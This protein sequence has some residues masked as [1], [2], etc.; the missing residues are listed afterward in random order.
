VA[1]GGEASR[2]TVTNDKRVHNV[3]EKGG[4]EIRVLGD[5]GNAIGRVDAAGHLVQGVESVAVSIGWLPVVDA[6]DVGCR[7][8]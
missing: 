1:R 6:L 8:S 5:H 2:D 3:D 4:A 7:E